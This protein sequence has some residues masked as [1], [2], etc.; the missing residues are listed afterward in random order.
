MSVF[1]AFGTCDDL[2]G[3]GA[4]CSLLLFAV[5]ACGYAG[6][7]RQ[8]AELDRLVHAAQEAESCRAAGASKADVQV[9]RERVPLR[10]IDEASL[11]Q[12]ADRK[13]A[14]DREKSALTVWSGVT[15]HCGAQARTALA[16]IG[17]SSHIPA[18]LANR[19]RQDHIFVQLVQGKIRWGDAVL[20]LKASRTV[21]WSAVA[22]ENDRRDTE[23][24]RSTEAARA[25]RTAILDAFTQMMP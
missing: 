5:A 17:L 6:E 7:R 22:E 23:F 14:S 8:A 21:L 20:R 19:D 25:N 16:R 13:F 9:L 11:E 24:E 1:G 2:K 15:G 4:A 3:I 10:N 12:L 18:I